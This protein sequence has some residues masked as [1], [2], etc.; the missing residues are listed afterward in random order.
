MPISGRIFIVT[1][2]R[3][4]NVTMRMKE[5][6]LHVTTPPFRSVKAL[7]DVIRPFRER[8]LKLKAECLPSLS[9]GIIGW[10][11]SASGCGSNPAG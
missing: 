1:C 8:L 2:V 9:I 7:L 4:G 3:C 6:G 5:D 10:R 11:R